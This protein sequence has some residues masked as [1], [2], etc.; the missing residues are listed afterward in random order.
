MKV[1]FTSGFPAPNYRKSVGLDAH[2]AFVTKPWT[3]SELLDRV[4]S[5]L[6]SSPK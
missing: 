4:R 1:L 5:L 2:V 6:E 3:A